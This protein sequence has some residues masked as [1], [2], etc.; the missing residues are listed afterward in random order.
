[1]SDNDKG[2]RQKMKKINLGEFSQEGY[3]LVDE[4]PVLEN[5]FETRFLD[6]NLQV[7]SLVMKDYHSEQVYSHNKRRSILT[8]VIT[9]IIDNVEL[10][11]ELK[12]DSGF[13]GDGQTLK[14][15]VENI[16]I[17]SGMHISELNDP[18][19]LFGIKGLSVAVI[20]SPPSVNER[21]DLHLL[22]L[23]YKG[24]L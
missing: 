1:M 7:L 12:F 16:Q 10:T 15:I 3:K 14:G 8:T 2:E 21:I 11:H 23:H 22:E 19:S 4:E 20:V 9:V 18:S 6:V 13:S 17:S 5:P 24:K